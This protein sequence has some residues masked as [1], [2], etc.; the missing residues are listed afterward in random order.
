MS[1]SVE[2]VLS[3]F[4][5]AA[6]TLDIDGHRIELSASYLSHA[7]DDLLRAA[8]SLVRGVEETSATF[9]EEPGE[10]RWLFRRVGID[11]LALRIV[12]FPTWPAQK[13]DAAGD[14]VFD[15]ECRLRGFAGAVLAAGQRLLQDQG[16]EGYR[17]TWRNHDFPLDRLRQLQATLRGEG[18]H[19]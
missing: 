18:K 11:R 17:A 9:V 2:Y 16:V 5:W 15:D 10:F 12:R 7:L 1:V 4:G 3:G 14:E 19:Q 13:P 8:T 6:C